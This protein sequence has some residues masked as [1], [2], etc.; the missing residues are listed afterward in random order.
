MQIRLDNR[1]EKFAEL[2][3]RSFGKIGLEKQRVRD[4]QGKSDADPEIDSISVSSMDPRG[5]K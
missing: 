5:K 2:E 3:I 4:V 1:D